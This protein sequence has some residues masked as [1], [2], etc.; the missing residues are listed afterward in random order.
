MKTRMVLSSIALWLLAWGLN[1]WAAQMSAGGVNLLCLGV[2]ALWAGL[3]VWRR[4][5]GGSWTE[6]ILQAGFAVGLI[7]VLKLPYTFSWHDLASYSA[8]FSTE[9]ARPDGHLGYV[10]YIVQNNALPLAFDPRINGYS[11]FYNPPLHH[12]LHAVWMKINLLLGAAEETALENTQLITWAFACGCSWVSISL[13]KE[14]GV[15]ER[16][17]RAGAWFM[18]FQPS[19]WLFGATVNND[20]QMV[21]LLLLCMLYTV[22]WYKGRKMADILWCGLS[23]GAAMAT[24]LNAALIIPCIALVFA[25]AFFRDLKNWKRYIPPFAAFLAVSVPIAMAWPV[26]HLAAFQMPFTYVRLPSETINVS[27]FTM[28]QR[29]GI[30]DGRVIRTLFYLP[31]RKLSHNVWM[32]T[33][34][35]GVFDELTLFAEGT[36]MWYAAYLTLVAFAALL[37]G[38]L[39]LFV[40]WL[41]KG[42]A[43]GLLKCFLAGYGA[44]LIGNYLIFTLQY[45]Y[46]CTFNF[47]YVM[48][49]LALCAVAWAD[50][51]QKRRWA[52]VFPAGFAFMS[53]AV[54]GVYLFA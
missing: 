8:D 20:I 33:L 31:T 5:K 40:R 14:L 53:A 36:T 49:V 42:K 7:F 37:L 38:A 29:Y 32:Q 54:Y 30:P 47:R 46:I 21:F 15:G 17:A 22:R 43:A 6:I 34:K 12:L 24:K 4:R 18:A 11:V 35:T 9:G 41:V 25:T 23:L 26:Y 39:A 27:H 45:P 10:A 50:F 44:I 13:L 52:V 51:A 2:V 16:G 19:L 1:T 48:P 3:S 28:W